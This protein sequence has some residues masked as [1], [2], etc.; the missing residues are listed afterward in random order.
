MAKEEV[1]GIL[2]VL[3]NCWLVQ[4]ILLPATR[5]TCVLWIISC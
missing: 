5:A 1:T 3:C 4:S 2:L